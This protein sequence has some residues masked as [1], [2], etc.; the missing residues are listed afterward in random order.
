VLA[1]LALAM[2]ASRGESPASELQA[3]E[4][5]LAAGAVA[6]EAATVKQMAARTRL[7]IQTVRRRLRL[8]AL[9]A[10]LREAFDQGRLP[11]SVAEAA[12][13]LPEA[14][15][16]ALAS[17]L[18]EGAGLTLARVREHARRQTSAATAELPDELFV[19][20]VAGWQTTVRGHLVAAADA[21]P[22]EVDL[23]PLRQS[24]EQ[25]LAEVERS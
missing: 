9:I 17:H 21:I 5:I 6:G 18:G 8:R 20:R 7:S 3:I 13:R 24:L 16:Q 22:D 19:E 25:A 11:A 12:A 15:Q 23:A 4:T 2:H 1:G 14:Q 10:E